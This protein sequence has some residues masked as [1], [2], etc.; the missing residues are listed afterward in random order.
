[1]PGRPCQRT[2]PLWWAPLVLETKGGLVRAGPAAGRVRGRWEGG[3]PGGL[4]GERVPHDGSRRGR[5]GAVVHRL[6]WAGAGR[7][8]AHAFHDYRDFADFQVLVW[9]M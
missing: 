7:R 4:P 8:L 1:M 9:W 6:G 5:P 2:C 3:T